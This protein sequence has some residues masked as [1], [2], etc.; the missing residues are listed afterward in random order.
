MEMENV[1]EEYQWNTLGE[2]K[3]QLSELEDQ[4]VEFFLYGSKQE[5]K[6]IYTQ[7]KKLKVELLL[8]ENNFKVSL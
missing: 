3:T 5:L 4:Y 6:R 7:I 2:L 8:K 1:C